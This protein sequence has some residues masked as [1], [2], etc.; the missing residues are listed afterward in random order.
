MRYECED[1]YANDN[2]VTRDEIDPEK[3]RDTFPYFR[4]TSVVSMDKIKQRLA[5][6]GA[7][8]FNLRRMKYKITNMP[9]ATDLRYMGGPPTIAICDRDDYYK[10]NKI[11]DRYQDYA[12]CRAKRYDNQYSTYEY[13]EQNW[14]AIYDAAIE[15]YGKAT[16]LTLRETLYAAQTEVGSF[17]CTNLAGM[18]ELVGAQNVLDFSSGWGDRLAAAVAK[19][20]KYTGVDP[21]TLLVEGYAEFISD[22]GRGYPQT[23]DP[24][25]DDKYKMICAPFEDVPE[26]EL[27]E[28]GPFDLVFTSPP[29]FNLEVYTD[30]KTQSANEESD[31]DK[32]YNDFLLVALRKSWNL[33]SNGGHMVIVINDIRNGPAFTMR[34]VRDISAFPGAQYN[35]VLSYSELIKGSYPKSPQPMWIWKKS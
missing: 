6:L 25:R 13:W 5:N 20:V 18:I 2:E 15:K 12:R 23:S 29:Y 11:S 22:F 1:I 28:R 26:E 14:G 10:Y 8:K 16:A 27:A 32:W 3:G 9:G 24:E 7:Y 21:N 33:M 17:R 4:Y 34:M 35:G 19:G 31:L 30:E